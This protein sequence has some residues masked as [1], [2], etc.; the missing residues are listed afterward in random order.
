[1]VPALKGG[2]VAGLTVTPPPPPPPREPW[3]GALHPQEQAGAGKPGQS[4]VPGRD[5]PSA[6]ARRVF[7]AAEK[8]HQSLQLTYS[9]A[10]KAG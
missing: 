6:L 5:P 8:G 1:M 9:L 10:S 2:L 4:Q 3:P 7:P